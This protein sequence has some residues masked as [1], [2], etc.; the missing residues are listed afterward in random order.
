MGKRVT[1]A[2]TVRFRDI[3]VMGHVNN[4]VF[5][6]YF[7]EGRKTFLREVWGIAEPAEYPFILARIA[8]DYLKPIQL[9]DR[10]SLSVGVAN[11][12]T[13]SFTFSYAL[14]DPA[15]ESVLYGRGE[16]VMV[17]YD[18]GTGTTVPIAPELAER[19][20]PFLE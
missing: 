17:M 11:L 15:D 18:Y 14:H 8:C 13:K 2:I 10:V 7:E 16:S 6:T 4:A 12:G 3:D 20:V 1:V 9:G 19:L 5:L